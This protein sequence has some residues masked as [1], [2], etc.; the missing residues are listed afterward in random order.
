MKLVVIVVG[1]AAVVSSAVA[2]L[3]ITLLS[4]W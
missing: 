1:V 2:T 4:G 3:G